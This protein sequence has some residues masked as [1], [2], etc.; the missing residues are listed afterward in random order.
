[1]ETLAPNMEVSLASRHRDAETVSKSQAAR[2]RVT[3]K[4]MKEKRMEVHKS[5]NEIKHIKCLGA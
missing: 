2:V 1:M 5:C 3:S 4:S